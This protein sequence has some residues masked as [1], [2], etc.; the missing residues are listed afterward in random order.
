MARKS[1]PAADGAP[2]YTV[3]IDHTVTIAV[4][5][6]TRR[7]VVVTAGTHMFGD[8]ADQNAALELLWSAFIATSPERPQIL[9]EPLVE[10]VV[11]T[12]TAS[13]ATAT[14]PEV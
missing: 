7:D 10:L 14:T 6:G 11:D 3:D 1:T 5:D 9:D 2:T 8:D 12:P 4:A 13:D